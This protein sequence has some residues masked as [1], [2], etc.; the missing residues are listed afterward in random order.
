MHR[1][2]QMVGSIALA[3]L[4]RML[5]AQLEAPPPV[6]SGLVEAQTQSLEKER[7]ALQSELSAFD[8]HVETNK[9]KCGAVDPDDNSLVADCDHSNADL[10]KEMDEYQARLDVYKKQCMAV[11]K[12]PTVP[13]FSQDPNAARLSAAQLRVVNG[14]IAGL[15][16][17]ITLLDNTNPEWARERDH[18]IESR[19]ED[20]NGLSV[21]LVNIVSLGLTEY[22]KRL[23]QSNVLSAHI[24]ALVKAFKKPL[25]QLPAEEARLNRIL[26]ETKDPTLASAI[27]EYT[28]ALHRL[29]DAKATKDLATMIARTRD[30]AE[31]LHSE[32]EVMK[33]HPPPK[34]QDM[35]DSLYMSST[36]VGQLALVFVAEG[37]AGVAA[38]A[39]S[40]A[41]SLAV[42]GREVVNLWQERSQLAT[43]ADNAAKRQNMKAELVGRLGDL[44]EQQERLVWA[45]QHASGGS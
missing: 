3:L 40:V 30:A 8:A 31:A 43:L 36:T 39:G 32:F 13:D 42:G 44:Q 14:R 41:S 45:V 7:T 6:P 4:P 11:A 28:S 1:R 22:W 18:M 25:A 12:Y 9:A 24:N 29:R 34:S 16:E 23:A 20:W 10:Q 38:A 21:E 15:Q 5:L 19:R 37:S 33:L 35:A 2:T 17:A 27:L 26:A